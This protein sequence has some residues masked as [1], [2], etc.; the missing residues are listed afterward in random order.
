MTEV[1]GRVKMTQQGAA[2]LL[3]ISVRSLQRFVK[4]G[5]LAPTYQRGKTRPVPIFDEAE[6]ETLR[7]ELWNRPVYPQQ[8]T[9][10]EQTKKQPFGLRLAPEEIQRLSEEAA[11][12]GRRPSEYARYLVQLGL[13]SAFRQEADHL[14]QEVVSL[15]SQVAGL[16]EAIQNLCDDFVETIEIV[17]EVAGMSSEEARRWVDENLRLGPLSLTKTE[18]QK[19]K[20]QGDRL[21]RNWQR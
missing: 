10:S 1:K 21:R 2:K 20:R 4:Q 18:A 12:Y 17:L 15:Q 8:Q 19:R 6:V 16:N 7:A 9:R 5:R 3:G 11:R 13:E 14:R